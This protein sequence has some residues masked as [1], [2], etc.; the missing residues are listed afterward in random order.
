[1]VPSTW[2]S[3][4]IVRSKTSFPGPSYTGIRTGPPFVNPNS[5]TKGGI[6]SDVRRG[7]VKVVARIE[8][9]VSDKLNTDP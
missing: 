3:P 8:G 4:H 7:V 9:R 5:S 2:W 6:R 1:M